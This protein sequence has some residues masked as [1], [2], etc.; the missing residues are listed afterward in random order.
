MNGRFYY[1]WVIVAVCG[2]TLL[3]AFGI[4]L[5][6][7]VFFVALIDEFHWA[8]ASTS[9]VFSV[10]MVVFTLASTWAGM[11]LD[12]W[13]A[14]RTF[15]F[16]AF[17]T[18]VGLLLSSQIR[19]LWQ[20]V[21]TYGV[22]AGLGITVLGLG[23]QA[24]LI[25][26]WFRRRRGL[27]IGIAFAGTGLG[28]LTLTPGV[29]QLI[30]R[31]GWRWAY[32]VLAGLVLLTIPLIVLFLRLNPADL[33]LL[34]DGEVVA[35]GG[36]TAVSAP[37]H[38][39]TM[40]EA[41]HTPAFWLL[42]L[43]SLGAIGPLRMLTVHQLAAVVDAGFDPVYASGVI[44]FAGAITAV[45]FVLFGL[46]SDRIGRRA[47]YALGSV[48]LLAAIGTLSQLTDPT[49][50]GSLF[51]YALMLGLGEGSRSSLVTAVASD[52][53]PGDAMGAING[54][55]GAAFGLG[56]AFF[57]WFAGRIFDLFGV[58]TI[59]FQIAGLAILISTLSLWLAPHLH[60]YSRK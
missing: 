59:A 57:P 3:V 46:L 26:R 2:L 10:S 50:T 54:A 22:V 38:N 39:W 56:A 55:V 12:R 49:Q 43:A 21:V 17:L 42:I 15:G 41:I 24:G 11:A 30:G 1:G 23:P 4:R 20:L 9:L 29:A 5:S 27:A 48:C 60:P 47:A 8:R 53:F 14:R 32:V 36:E 34:P 44:G 52:L 13:G 7:T 58:Y 40:R 28:T 19:T 35:G 18:A 6:F 37:L 45:S 16:G 51:F 33:G 25:S 31:V